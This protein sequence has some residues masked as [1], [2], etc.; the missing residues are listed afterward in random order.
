MA[1]VMNLY[2]KHA[3]TLRSPTTAKFHAARSGRYGLKVIGRVRREKQW[4]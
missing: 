4:P 3:D 1:E 2:L